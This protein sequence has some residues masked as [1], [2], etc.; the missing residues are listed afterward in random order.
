[1]Q[2]NSFEL[3]IFGFADGDASDF[4][5]RSSML[6]SIAVYPLFITMQKIFSFL[7]LN[8]LFTHEKTPF[9]SF[10][11]NLYDIQCPCFWIIPNTL[12]RFKTV[13]WSTPNDST[14]S[15]RSDMSF[16]EVMPPIL[17]LQI[18]SVHQ[19]VLYLRHQNH[20]FWNI[21]LISTCCFRQSMI[22]VRLNKNYMC[23]SCRFFKNKI[24]Q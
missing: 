22:V 3:W 5:P 12:K 6:R 2:N 4:I 19:T 24:V 1:M 8:Q 20:Y 11:F 15:A 13:V 10:D 14:S 7:P 16:H 18:F 21:K 23:F 9:D 17:R